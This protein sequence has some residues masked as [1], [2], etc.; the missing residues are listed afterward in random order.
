[1]STH[2]KHFDYKIGEKIPTYFLE[3]MK[4]FPMNSKTSSNEQ[5]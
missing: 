5:R 3:L 1:M 2:N 4:E